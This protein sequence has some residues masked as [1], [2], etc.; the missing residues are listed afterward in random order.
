MATCS[1]ESRVMSRRSR[2]ILG[3]TQ[4]VYLALARQTAGGHKGR[5][6]PYLLRMLLNIAIFVDYYQV[7]YIQ[8]RIV[9]S[10]RQ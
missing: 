8:Y 9:S 6:N 1:K 5:Y 3:E 4:Y 10:V 7:R 2:P